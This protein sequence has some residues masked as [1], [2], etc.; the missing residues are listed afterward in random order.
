MTGCVCILAVAAAA[1]AAAAAACPL[2]DSAQFQLAVGLVPV[3]G[4]GIPG[5]R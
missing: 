3:S 1:A 5:Q 4:G 2:S